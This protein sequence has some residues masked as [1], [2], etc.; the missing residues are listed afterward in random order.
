MQVRVCVCTCVCHFQ[1]CMLQ[2]I[3]VVQTQFDKR[4]P[5]YVAAACGQT[6]SIIFLLKHNATPLLPALNGSTPFDITEKLAIKK[7]SQIGTPIAL[8]VNA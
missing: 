4:T 1:L 3:L 7:Y 8:A 2:A 5:L 6:D